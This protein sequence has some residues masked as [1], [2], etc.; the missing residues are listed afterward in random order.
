MVKTQVTT[1]NIIYVFRLKFYWSLSV[2]TREQNYKFFCK[3]VN[4]EFNNLI[5]HLDLDNLNKAADLIRL[6][7]NCGNRLHISGIGKPSYVAGYAASLFSSTGTPAYYLHGTEAVHG[8][9]GQLVPGDIVLFIS[10]SGETNEMR[11]TITAVKN[12]GCKIISITGN[13]DSWLAKKSDI[14]LFS[15]ISQEGGPL[16][17]APRMSIIAEIFVIQ[18]LS[19]F[20]QSDKNLTPQQYVKWHP[21]GKLGHLREE[22]MRKC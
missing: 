18:S 7:E 22:E 21:G 13:S 6:S 8:S 14:H 1:Q 20:L 3:T 11:S 19:I 12:N 2:N 5:L 15:G 17:R 9:C 10:N 4:E 16:N